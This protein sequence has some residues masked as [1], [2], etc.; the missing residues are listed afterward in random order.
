MSSHVTRMNSKQDMGELLQ[1]LGQELT[2]VG[3]TFEELQQY[4]SNY[5]YTFCLVN[6]INLIYCPKLIGLSG[7]NPTYKPVL[8]ASSRACYLK[9][10]LLN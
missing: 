8:P 1:S 5:I 4:W 6:S 2:A 10:I 7:D 9:I 3:K